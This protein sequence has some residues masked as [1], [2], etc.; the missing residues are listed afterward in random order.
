MIK[1]NQS[2]QSAAQAFFGYLGTH[3][4]YL[5]ASD[6]FYFL[7]RSERAVANL[8]T[9]DDL[10]PERIAEMLDTVAQQASALPLA[11]PENLEEQID[12]QTVGKSMDRFIWEFGSVAH[13]AKR[14]DLVC[15]N[16][17]VCHR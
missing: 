9:L 5:C 11:K 17:P 12:R 4:P 8:G 3:L 15:E 2:I 6:E 16:P 10:E 1:N 7:P 14:P 13:M